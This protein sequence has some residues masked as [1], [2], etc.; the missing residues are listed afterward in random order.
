ERG[1]ESRTLG[2]GLAPRP[3]FIGPRWRMAGRPLGGMN[4]LHL[5]SV[6]QGY[7]I[8]KSLEPDND[9][10]KPSRGPALPE[11]AGWFCALE[12]PT[13]PQYKCGAVASFI[14]RLQREES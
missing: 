9:P 14:D 12:A 10:V 4:S 6:S 2:H 3:T 5:P 13:I 1:L 11:W 7:L 8:T